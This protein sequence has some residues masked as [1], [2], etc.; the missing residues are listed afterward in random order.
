[1]FSPWQVYWLGIDS[2]E[3]KAGLVSCILILVKDKLELLF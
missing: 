1:M 2:L 3:E